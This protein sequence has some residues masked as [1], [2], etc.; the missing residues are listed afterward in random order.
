MVNKL[1]FTYQVQTQGQFTDPTQFQNIILRSD[2]T[3]RRSI[4]RTSR[5]SSSARSTTRSN[6]TFNGKPVTPIRISL[7]PGAN[8]LETTRLV[9]E[10]MVELAKSFPSGIEYKVP[11]DTTRFVHV[12]IHEVVK[13]FL[14]A[15]CWWCSSSSSSCRTCGRRRFPSSRCRCR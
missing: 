2:K 12:S 6:G 14:E 3:A 9:N 8:A 15:I 13:T 10:K 4:S 1:A 11:F 7:M 5:A